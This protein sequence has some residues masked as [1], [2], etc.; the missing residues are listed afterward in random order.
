MSTSVSRV[1]EEC[2]EDLILGVVQR[3]RFI[4]AGEGCA[5]HILPECGKGLDP[6]VLRLDH[7]GRKVIVDARMARHVVSSFAQDVGGK[8]VLHVA[9]AARTH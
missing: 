2:G 9:A 7:R 6:A 4:P 5:C 3:H 8:K 1:G